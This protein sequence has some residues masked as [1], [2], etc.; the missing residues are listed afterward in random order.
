MKYSIENRAGQSLE[1]DVVEVEGG[2]YQVR[3]DG[4]TLE[5]DFA[6][7]DRLGQCAVLLGDRSFGASV[8]TEA[9]DET[10]LVVRI[11]GFSYSFRVF[12]ERELAAGVLDSPGPGRAEV[13]RAAMPGII[14]GVKVAAGE[15]VEPGAPLVVLEAMKM[16]NEVGSVHG[17]VVAEVRVAVG[18][19]VSAGA[20]LVRLEPPTD[21]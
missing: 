1:G 21:G 17:G 2:R 8:E 15:R 4:E 11:A 5:A 7:V 18:Q 19:T 14:V 3:V 10:H 12:D 6:D 9:G 16:Q 20:A 13:V